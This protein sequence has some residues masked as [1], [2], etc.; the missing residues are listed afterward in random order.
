MDKRKNNVRR[1]TVG[2]KEIT[3]KLD[4]V[5]RRVLRSD[6]VRAKTKQLQEFGY[7][8]LTEEDVDSQL[9]ALL[10][11]KNLTVIGMFMKDEVVKEAKSG[12]E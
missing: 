12:K 6:Y 7:P 8:S 9:T 11:G 2:I 10:A 4:G 1:L 5:S 3:F